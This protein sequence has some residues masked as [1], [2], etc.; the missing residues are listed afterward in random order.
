MFSHKSLWYFGVLLLTDVYA[1]GVKSRVDL[2][3][4]K[5]IW[6]CTRVIYRAHLF[7]QQATSSRRWR[8]VTHDQI[9]RFCQQKIHI[10]GFRALVSR[11]SGSRARECCSDLWWHDSETY[12]WNEVIAG[13]ND[14]TKAA[15]SKASIFSTA[16][17]MSWHYIRWHLNWSGN[18]SSIVTQDSQ[19]KTSQSVYEERIDAQNGAGYVCK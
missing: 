9:T 18:Q 5:D 13:I 17:I 19:A 10:K 8:E 4:D 2:C 12:L 15:Q 16:C 6:K 7:T 1:Q 3:M 11:Q 14:H